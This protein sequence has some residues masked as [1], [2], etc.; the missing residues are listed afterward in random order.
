MWVRAVVIRSA[1]EK[2]RGQRAAG[3]GLDVWKG[4]AFGVMSPESSEKPRLDRSAVRCDWEAGAGW[5]GEVGELGA[6]WAT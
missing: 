6:G 3:D 1:P 2:L 4:V 5:E